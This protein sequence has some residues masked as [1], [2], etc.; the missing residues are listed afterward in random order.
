MEVIV[1]ESSESWDLYKV[2]QDVE[3]VDPEVGYSI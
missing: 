2:E 3:V 1:E